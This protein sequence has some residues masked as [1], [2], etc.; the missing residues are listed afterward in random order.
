MHAADAAPACS[1]LQEAYGRLDAREAKARQAEADLADARTAAQV[2]SWHWSHMPG[3]GCTTFHL[4]GN[5]NSCFSASAASPPAS[6]TPRPPA[7]CVATQQA[8][9][10]AA[11]LAKR[12]LAAEREELAALREE[13]RRQQ[14]AAAAEAGRLAEL[15]QVGRSS[16][17]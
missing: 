9:L 11:E 13:L 5:D 15:Q 8:D 3:R 1:L 14:A 6:S 7:C 4:A 12:S 17:A 2:R 16:V 10:Q